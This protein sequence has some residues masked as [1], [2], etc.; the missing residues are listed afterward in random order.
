MTK[1]HQQGFTLLEALLVVAVI[2]ILAAITIL[3]INPGRQLAQTRNAQRRVDV[4][5]IL[6]GVYQFSLDNQGVLP[7]TITTAPTEICRDGTGDCTGLASLAVLTPTY[8]V[9]IPTDPQLN[10]C[11][12]STTSSPPVPNRG[13]CYEIFRTTADRVTVRAPDREL[14]IATIEVTR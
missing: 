2:G 11:S 10:T 3:A 1:K 8:I 4:N 14:G 9:A 12:G 13:A 5:T 6:N 7:T